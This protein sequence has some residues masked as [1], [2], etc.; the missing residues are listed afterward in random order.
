LSKERVSALAKVVGVSSRQL[1]DWLNANGEYVKTPSST[2]EGVVVTKVLTQFPG[3]ALDQRQFVQPPPGPLPGAVRHR[4]SAWTV[5]IRFDGESDWLFLAADTE[6]R[7]YT[8]SQGNSR[9]FKSEAAAQAQADRELEKSRI[10]E[11]TIV[12]IVNPRRS[13]A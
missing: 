9:R 13:A 4:P 5:A 1:I 2:V 12:E 11:A 3:R 6:R 7:T 8:R 10:R